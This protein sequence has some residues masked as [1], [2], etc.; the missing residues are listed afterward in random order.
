MARFTGVFA[1]FVAQEVHRHAALAVVDVGL[2][3][4]AHQRQLLDHLAAA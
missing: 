4:H 2:V 1:D 3:L